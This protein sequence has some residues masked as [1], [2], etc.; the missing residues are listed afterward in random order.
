MYLVLFTDLNSTYRDMLS[1]VFMQNSF[2]SFI[3][4][5]NRT[6]EPFSFMLYCILP[7]CGQWP[8]FRTLLSCFEYIIIRPLRN[9][10]LHMLKCQNIL[11]I[12]LIM[13]IWI[14]LTFLNFLIGLLKF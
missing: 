10:F 6:P 4:I 5:Y 9:T 8:E 2:R 7:N 3:F 1:K 13:N 11:K 12:L 14:I